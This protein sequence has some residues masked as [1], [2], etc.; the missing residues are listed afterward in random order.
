[1]RSRGVLPD[2][3]SEPADKIRQAAVA[4]ALAADGQQPSDRAAVFRTFSG[5]NADRN[6]DQGHAVERQQ[7]QLAVHELD[8]TQRVAPA[9]LNITQRMV[10]S[11]RSFSR[12]FS[13]DSTHR[14]N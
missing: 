11:G 6:S 13:S 4:A 3:I 14:T 10:L 1:M 8:V 9:R 7:L 12:R 5:E 2:A